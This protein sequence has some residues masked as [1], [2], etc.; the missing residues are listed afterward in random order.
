M[1]KILKQVV[2]LENQG[3]QFEAAEASFDLLVTTGGRAT[4]QPHFE[5]VQYHTSVV[6]RGGRADYRSHRQAARSTTNCVTK[7]PRATVR[8][9]LWTLPCERR[10]MVIFRA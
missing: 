3:Y 5:L 4:Y 2:E 6:S 7:W 10:S 8:S 9:T 1:N